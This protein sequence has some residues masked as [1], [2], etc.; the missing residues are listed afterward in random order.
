MDRFQ[1]EN[2]AHNLELVNAISSVAASK[3]VT[4]AQ[5]AIA[6]VGHLGA[7]VMPLAGSSKKER[8]LENLLGG[9]ITLSRDELAEIEEIISSVEVKGGRYYEK[10]A[11]EMHLWG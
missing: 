3:G 6:W 9:N 11:A 1:P 4:P 7:H 5:L 8:T 2:F 10:R